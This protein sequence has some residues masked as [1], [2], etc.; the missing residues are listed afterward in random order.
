MI[1]FITHGTVRNGFGRKQQAMV[2]AR[3][4]VWLQSSQKPGVN[5]VHRNGRE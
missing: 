5:A 1:K 4:I 3:V 2:V